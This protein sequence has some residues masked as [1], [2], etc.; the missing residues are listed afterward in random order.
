MSGRR[1][2]PA[3]GNHTTQPR[4]PELRCLDQF[5]HPHVAPWHTLCNSNY[6]WYSCKANGAITESASRDNSPDTLMTLTVLQLRPH[7]WDVSFQ[8]RAVVL[9]VVRPEIGNQ[10]SR[11]VKRYFF[12]KS[13]TLF[14]GDI[15]DSTIHS[16]IKI[17]FLWGSLVG[18]WWYLMNFWCQYKSPIAPV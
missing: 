16:K 7:V 18:P 8:F 4:I 17:P 11:F 3:Q 12:N 13:S 14:I 15:H 9:T 2:R 5:T 10:E 1:S 6:L